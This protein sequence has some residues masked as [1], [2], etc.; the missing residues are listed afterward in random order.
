MPAQNDARE[1]EMR[2][3]FNLS[4][5]AADTTSTLTLKPRVPLHE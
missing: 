3:L 4:N 1:R 2:Q 5:R